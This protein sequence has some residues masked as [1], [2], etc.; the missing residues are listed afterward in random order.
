MAALALANFA[1]FGISSSRALDHSKETVQQ[2]QHALD[3]RILVEQAKGM[4]AE[5]VGVSP[6]VAFQALRRYARHHQRPMRDVCRDVIDNMLEVD[7]LD[8]GTG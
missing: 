4:L 6:S 3:S 5:R 1:A 2:L 8:V 7:A